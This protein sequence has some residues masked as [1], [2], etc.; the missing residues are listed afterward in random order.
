MACTDEDSDAGKLLL[1]FFNTVNQTKAAKAAAAA[2]GSGVMVD[3][4]DSGVVDLKQV[5]DIAHDQLAAAPKDGAGRHVLVADDSASTR[6]FLKV[7]LERNGYVVDTAENG[8]DALESMKRQTYDIVFMD[9]EMPIMNGFS[10]SAAFREWE[11]NTDR[12]KRQPI[13]VLSMHSGV[14]EKEMCAE[15][16][17]DFF[18]AK[19]ARIPGLMKIAELCIKLQNK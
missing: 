3:G 15:V 16:G 10:C 1:G 11:K 6:R 19:P 18:E 7:Q 4:D 12:D 13:C 9:L 17:V 8:Q 14:K 5:K 2:A